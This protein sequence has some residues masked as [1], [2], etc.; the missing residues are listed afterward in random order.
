MAGSSV[1]TEE[2]V[3]VREDPDFYNGSPKRICAEL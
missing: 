3:T 1:T 2:G